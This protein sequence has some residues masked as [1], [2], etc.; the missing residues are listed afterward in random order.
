[1]PGIERNL[2]TLDR[3]LLKNWPLIWRTRIHWVLFWSGVAH[4]LIFGLY[5]LVPMTTASMPTRIGVSNFR[6]SILVLAGFALLVWFLNINRFAFKGKR[7]RS[8]LLQFSICWLGTAAIGLTVWNANKV[9]DQKIAGL[10]EYSQLYGD[11][12]YTS[13]YY[14][15]EKS[16]DR[17][18]QYLQLKARYNIDYIYES[19]N[20]EHYKEL[21]GL[22]TFINLT[23]D[24]IEVID[25]SIQVSGWYSMNRDYGKLNRIIILSLICFPLIVFLFS[26]GGL[27]YFILVG[28]VHFLLFVMVI[29]YTH[30]EGLTKYYL[31]S[32]LFL[33][34]LGL[35]LFKNR[36]FLNQIVLF[37]IST[38]PIYLFIYYLEI[39]LSDHYQ[40]VYLQHIPAPFYTLTVFSLLITA[41]CFTLY[42]KK[43]NRPQIT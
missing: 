12:H 19:E 40:Y 38:V 33:T 24:K 7:F 22:T 16:S 10:V 37:L 30:I 21:H 11:L 34:G 28:F 32:S 13:S 27:L 26:Y 9:F 20:S 31:Y 18:N 35:L 1:M 25:E 41:V 3:W 8:V 43:S 2:K 15:Q 4:L 39:R 6:I 23:R 29:K 17:Y 14:K 36:L 5:W 42:I